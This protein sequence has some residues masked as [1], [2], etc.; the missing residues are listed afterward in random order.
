MSDAPRDLP[1]LLDAAEEALYSHGDPA[2]CIELC[3]DGLKRVEGEDVFVDLVLLK[4]EAEIAAELDGFAVRTLD[5]LSSCVIEDAGTLCDIGQLWWTLADE[6]KAGDAFARAVAADADLAD[7]H[8]GLGLV[9]EATDNRAEMVRSF[10]RTLELDA[11][12]PESEVHLELDA[13]QRIAEAAMAELPPRALELLENVP[14]LIAAAPDRH[15]VE[16][17][18][19]PRL[20]GLFSGSSLL[21]KESSAGQAPGVDTIHLYQRNLERVV[22]DEEHLAEEIRITLLHETAH[23]FGL[24]DDDLGALGLG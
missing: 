8:Y 10:L 4:A 1:T 7:A 23:Y 2:T 19:D 5:E 20:L 12:A 17:G 21:E 16:T 24:E 3:D 14:I 22:M 15:L 11:A 13:F 6:D 18:T 9:H